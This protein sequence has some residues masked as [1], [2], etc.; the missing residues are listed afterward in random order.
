MFDVFNIPRRLLILWSTREAV[1]LLLAAINCA[2][3]S[4]KNGLT[5]REKYPWHAPRRGDNGAAEYHGNTHN[6]AFVIK[7][8]KKAPLTENMPYTQTTARTRGS[9]SKLVSSGH[10]RSVPSA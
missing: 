10:P 4:E 7:T 8:T 3:W 6:I 1:V 2:A 9:A 5:P